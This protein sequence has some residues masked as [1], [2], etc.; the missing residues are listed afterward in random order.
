MQLALAFSVAKISDGAQRATGGA[1]GFLV[2]SASNKAARI[3]RK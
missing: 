2:V 3:S 1:V